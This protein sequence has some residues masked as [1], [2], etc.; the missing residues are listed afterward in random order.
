[1]KPTL[2]DSELSVFAG[3][4]AMILHSGISVLE[5]I[6]ILRE[7]NPSEEGQQ[8]LSTVYE[9][10]EMTGD[11]AQSLRESGVY[12][13]YFLKMTELGERSGTLEEVMDS[14]SSYYDRQH[15]LLTGIR[16]ALTYPLILMGMLF[17]ILAVLM[18]Q[19]MPVF[20]EVFLQ[21]GIEVGGITGSVFFIGDLMQ[22]GAAIVL[23]LVAAA[24]LFCFLALRTGKGKE[25]LIAFIQRIP[26]AA[27]I[28][29]QLAR[30]RFANALSIALHS[31]L[32]MGEGFEIARELTDEKQFQT[33]LDQAAALIDEGNDFSDSLRQTGVFTGMDARMVSIGFKTGSAEV[34]LQKISGS[35]QEEA[36]NKIQNAVGMLEPVLTAILS[37]LTGVILVSVMLPLLGVMANLGA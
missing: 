19:V 12:P 17:A 25:Q 15:T 11:L 22:K 9:S 32:D 1:M 8:I 31:G 24:V 4:L 16:D 14:L 13:E 35:C 33:M 3:Q 26:L 2:T 7:D 10:L 28:Y 21:L 20:E 37:I 34:A 6:S 27:S 23:L 5:G 29:Q 36:D 30:S 18:T